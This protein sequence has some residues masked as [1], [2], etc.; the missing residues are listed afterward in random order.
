[1]LEGFLLFN[2]QVLE[3]QSKAATWYRSMGVSYKGEGSNFLHPPK[4]NPALW[5]L[6]DIPVNHAYDYWHLMW[7][8]RLRELQWLAEACR[9]KGVFPS[10]TVSKWLQDFSSLKDHSFKSF[11]FVQHTN[12]FLSFFSKA[13]F[14]KNDFFIELDILLKV[15]WENKKPGFMLFSIKHDTN[16]ISFLSLNK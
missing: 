14:L 4:G 12:P 15:L 9:N 3:R 6:I 13:S 7:E 8:V 11:Y 5:L 2:V 1:M 16:V 10:Q